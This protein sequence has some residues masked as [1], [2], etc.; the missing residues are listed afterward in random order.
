MDPDPGGLKTYGSGS[1][2]LVNHDPVSL[3]ADYNLSKEKSFSALFI[4]KSTGI[5]PPVY[6]DIKLF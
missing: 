3:K 2:T 5:C 1:S 4:E 6:T